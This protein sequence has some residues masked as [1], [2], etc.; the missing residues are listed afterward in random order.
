M[1][2]RCQHCIAS[3]SR[4]A[5]TA[6]PSTQ[7]PARRLTVGHPA[8]KPR[9]ATTAGCQSAVTHAHAAH[10]VMKTTHNVTATSVLGEQ[11]CLSSKHRAQY[12][13]PQ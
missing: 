6:A 5:A 11:A 2:S 1:V 13:A 4:D 9:Y 3:S 10:C 7:P 12:T 8:A